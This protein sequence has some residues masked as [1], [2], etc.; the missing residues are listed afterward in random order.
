[1]MSA[2]HPQPTRLFPPLSPTAQFSLGGGGGERVTQAFMETNT[3]PTTRKAAHPFTAHM[4]SAQLP[5]PPSQDLP[6]PS[7]VAPPSHHPLPAFPTPD[8]TGDQG[9]HPVCSRDFTSG[10]HSH[11]GGGGASALASL[12]GPSVQGQG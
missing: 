11:W 9:L 3:V 12:L 10:F 4:I 5:H 6:D 1:M 8:V 2:S 7:P